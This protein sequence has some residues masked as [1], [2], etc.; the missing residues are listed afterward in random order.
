MLTTCNATLNRYSQSNTLIN[1]QLRHGFLKVNN[2]KKRFAAIILI[3]STLHTFIVS[4]WWLTLIYQIL[5]FEMINRHDSINLHKILWCL[6]LM[7]FG[8]F[9][10]KHKQFG[11]STFLFKKEKLNPHNYNY[12]LCSEFIYNVGKHACFYL[13]EMFPFN[14]IRWNYFDKSHSELFLLDGFYSF[15][16]SLHWRISDL[17]FF[18]YYNKNVPTAFKQSC[19]S[20]HGTEKT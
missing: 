10:L 19:S 5:I 18:S 11:L 12:L 13:I 17:I 8:S 20:M 6:S 4:R 16:A 2:L 3:Y 15:W 9:Y 1:W 14:T 7:R